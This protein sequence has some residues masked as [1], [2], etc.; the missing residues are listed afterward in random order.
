M[1]LSETIY[2]TGKYTRIFLNKLRIDACLSKEKE[3]K[4]QKTFAL[5]NGNLAPK[6]YSK[7]EKFLNSPNK[8]KSL[9]KIVGKT[10]THEKKIPKQNHIKVLL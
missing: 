8:K 6:D 7:I 1:S 9:E 5:K 10:K 4:K 3:K 2:S